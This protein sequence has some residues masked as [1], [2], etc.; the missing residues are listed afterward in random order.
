MRQQHSSWLKLQEEMRSPKETC[1][2]GR[3]EGLRTDLG[4]KEKRHHEEGG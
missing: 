2:L 4:I 1:C 3:R